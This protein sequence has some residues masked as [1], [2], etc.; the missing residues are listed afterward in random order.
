[1]NTRALNTEKVWTTEFF[2]LFVLSLS[3]L[4]CLPLLRTGVVLGVTA[5][6]VRLYDLV[7]V[8]MFLFVL[9]PMLSQIFKVWSSLSMAHKFLLY[10]LLL[11]ILGLV[12][13]LITRENRFIIGMIRYFR[14]FSF[15]IVFVLG[16]MF[17]QNRK[18][19]LILFDAMIIC[20]ALIS[21]VGSLQGI[22]IVPNLWPDYYAIYS[23]F[24]GGYLSTATLAPNHTHY[25][26]I[27]AF[28]IIMIIS[29]FTISFRL[30]LLNVI[31][32]LSLFPMLYSMIASR[33]RSGWLVLGIYL[34]V[35][36]ILS[37]NIKG[38]VF[39][40]LLVGGIGIMF[41]GN[42]QA[43]NS[44]VQDILLYRSINTN[45][46][47]G[48]TALDIVD[49][50]EKNWIERV[51]DNRWY[52]Y[53]KSIENLL[54]NPQYLLIG[55]GFQN[56]SRGIGNVALAAHNA[57]INVVAEHGLIGLFI[58]LSF[59][60][61]LYRFGAQAKNNANNKAS[62]TMALNWICLFAGLLVANFFGEIIYPGRALFTFLGTFFII[63]VLFLHPAWRTP[64][65]MG[66]KSTS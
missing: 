6:E 48:K 46:Q 23:D 64:V 51:D 44:S 11:G 47:L 13:T 12:I 53:Q 43:G 58:Y 9:V 61:Y 30:S 2:F 24:D 42:I 49:D 25:S 17:I 20:I 36:L 39:G 1:M 5:S 59:L 35:N 56:A 22:N 28:G 63:A 10:W 57:Y 4:Y 26:L 15:S 3:Y 18:Q 50:E 54:N 14:F 60:Y 29:R 8:V 38:F 7:F 32:S 41:E 19:L 27:M 34:V 21:V 37:R 66:K 33:G 65:S 16:F 45:K 62:Y 40:V 52:I 31:Y 55:A